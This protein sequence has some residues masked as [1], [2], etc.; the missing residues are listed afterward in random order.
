M[1]PTGNEH[2]KENIRENTTKTHQFVLKDDDIFMQ[3]YF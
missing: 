2:N 3:D 1:S